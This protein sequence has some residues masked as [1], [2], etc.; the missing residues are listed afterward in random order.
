MDTSLT[1][2]VRLGEVIRQQ[3]AG[4]AAIGI[5]LRQVGEVLLH[6]T[7]FSPRSRCL[8]FGQRHC[9]AGLNAGFDLLAVEVAAVRDHIERLGVEGFLRQLGHTGEL[10][11]VI[12]DVDH[13]VGDDQ[14]VPASCGAALRG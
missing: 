13:V 8:R 2:F 10:G 1:T 9:D 6:K 5:L 4:R 11:A 14:M 12:A 3:L 7:A